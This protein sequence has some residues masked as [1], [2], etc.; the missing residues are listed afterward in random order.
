MSPADWAALWEAQGGRCYLCGGE[1]AAGN[2]CI[3]HDHSCCPPKRSCAVCRRGLSCRQ[4]NIAIGMASD[5]P[6]RLRRMAAALEAA[7][8]MVS[9]R[10]AG[11]PRQLELADA[12]G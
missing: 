2:G 1:L 12:S 3:D 9:E 5:D 11:A 7:Q 6:S 8:L 4:C 10:L